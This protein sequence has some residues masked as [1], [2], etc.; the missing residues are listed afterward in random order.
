MLRDADGRS[1]GIGY[2]S[3]GSGETCALPKLTRSPHQ[4]RSSF[5]P[6]PAE[7][8]LRQDPA[9]HPAQDCRRRLRCSRR[10]FDACRSGSRRRSDRQPAEQDRWRRVTQAMERCRPAQLHRI[11]VPQI[12]LTP[13]TNS[14][15]NDSGRARA[16]RPA[17]DLLLWG[18]RCKP[19]RSHN[20]LTGTHDLLVVIRCKAELPLVTAAADSL[21][22][23]VASWPPRALASA[24]RCQLPAPMLEFSRERYHL[25]RQG[26]HRPA[27]NCDRGATAI[28]GQFPSRVTVNRESW[29]I[30]G[31]RQSG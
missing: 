7:G 25:T 14:G 2:A 23:K 15:V 5:A 28:C 12:P 1:R 18:S 26:S 24:S 3:P 21:R 22:S 8:P 29:D 31:C 16:S 9:P 6:R 17:S 10:H 4:T 19:G 20:G 11:E 30:W 13:P 27:K